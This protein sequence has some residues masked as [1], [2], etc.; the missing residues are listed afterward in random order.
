MAVLVAVGLVLAADTKDAK[1][2]SDLVQGTWVG[3]E[4]V[5]NGEAAP[6]EEAAKAKLII[7]ADKYKFHSGDGELEGS[8]KLDPA[9]NPK[10][11]D[12]TPAGGDTLKAIYSVT[13]KEFKL[14]VSLT[15]ERPKEFSSKADSG[16]ILMVMKKE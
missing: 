3:V 11:M 5:R 9:T 16:C 7:K 14:C 8:F 15:G 13:D 10:H 12:V 2:D 6:K 1:K 4:L